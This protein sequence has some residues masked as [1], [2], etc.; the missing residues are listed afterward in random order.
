[1]LQCCSLLL[2]SLLAQVGKLVSEAD[3]KAEVLQQLEAAF[4]Q[5]PAPG[6][7]SKGAKKAGK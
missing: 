2:L 5:A 7:D 6:G 1:M 3:A 4:K